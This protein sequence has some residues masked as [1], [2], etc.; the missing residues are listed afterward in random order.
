MGI[1][2]LYACQE[3]TSIKLLFTQGP[4]ITFRLVLLVMTS[5]L[6]MTL[7]QRQ[8]HLKTLRAG[9]SL[10]VA[11][12]EY[13][14]DMPTEIGRWFSDSLQSRQ[15]L[16]EEN[17]R[18]HSQNLLMQTRSLKNADLEAENRRLRELLGSSFKVTDRVLIAELF[19]VDLNPYKHLIRINKTARHGVYLDQPL[20][21]AFGVMGQV[22]EVLPSHSTVR[23][24]T[25]PGHSIPVQVNRNGL[26]TLATGTG[27]INQINLPYLPNNADIT[28]GDLLV[29]S[30]LG[31]I[32]PPGY[33]VASITKIT[34]EPGE[35]FSYIE[36]EPLAHLNRSR[37]VLLVWSGKHIDKM[38]LHRP[39]V[40][41]LKEGKDEK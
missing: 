40:K 25:D 7:D 8:Q 32:Y 13:L 41:R 36:A 12:I 3:E 16:L 15:Q 1:Q 5:I 28:V 17:T 21:D 37:E 23:L 38:K 29:T 18:L 26:R 24:I 19:Q 10:L 22:I 4:S 35:E 34:H 33:P 20:L 11:P 14:A 39:S 2:T 31:G 6:L 27:K 30:G 9:L